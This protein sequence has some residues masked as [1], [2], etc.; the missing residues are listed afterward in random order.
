MKKLTVVKDEFSAEHHIS[1]TGI[2]VFIKINGVTKEK[3]YSTVEEC[4]SDVAYIID[5]A[6]Y[7][8]QAMATRLATLFSNTE[9]YNVT[10]SVW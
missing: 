10:H 8:E 7:K 1:T 2:R 9:G 4:Y 6:C 5:N 3:C